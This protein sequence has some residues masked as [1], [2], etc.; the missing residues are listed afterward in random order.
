[1]DLFSENPSL[2]KRIYQAFLL[3]GLTLGAIR[4]GY[5]AV[6]DTVPD[7]LKALLA[8]YAFL[9]AG[10]GFLAQNNVPENGDA[11]LEDL[12]ENDDDLL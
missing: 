11:D 2:R 5:E 4:V 3:I 10:V 7:L 1:M 6:D 8:S 9:G 12:P